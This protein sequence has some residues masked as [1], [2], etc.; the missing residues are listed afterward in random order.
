[1]ETVLLILLAIFVFGCLIL[2]HELGHYLFARLF[3][4]HIREFSIGMGPKLLQKVSP[5]TQIA[6]S[7]RLLPIGGYVAMVGEDE[8]VDDPR[9][10]YKKPVW[11][12]IL[13]TAA[14][15]VVNILIGFLLTFFMVCSMQNLGSTVVHSFTEESV[16]SQF[17]CE[18]DQIIKVGNAR[19]YTSMD[20]IYEITRLGIEPIDVT[21]LRNGEEILLENVV[22]PTTTSSGIL[23]GDMDFYVYAVPKTPLTILK[24]SASYCVL[25]V[26]QV[27]E[28]LY[29]L[30]RG[31]YGVE[32]VS[33]PVGV[34]EQI[35]E[36]TKAGLTSFLYLIS[37]ISVNLGLVN[38]LPLPALDGGRLL[39]QW[40][41][42][43]FR[44]KVNGKIEASIHTAGLLLLFL[45]MI[46]IT[47]K[48]IFS[49]F[50]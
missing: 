17:L 39:F 20:L 42:L 31:R 35:G 36:A 46:L 5:K 47:F 22:F 18:E 29:D 43:I 23:F 13:I 48:D 4:V 21:V 26:R 30:L 24:Q 16:S 9:A 1:L 3:D 40:I 44:K 7:L 2:V 41:E 33:G 19:V 27:W 45:L 37:L 25:S 15:G 6:Y 32:A 14:G 28:S 8:E 38:L 50:Q 10:L 12:R 34:T 11:Q 49:L